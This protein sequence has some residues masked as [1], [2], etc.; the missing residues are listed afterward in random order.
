MGIDKGI[1]SILAN[2]WITYSKTKSKS[3]FSLRNAVYLLNNPLPCPGR[4][5]N[6]YNTKSANVTYSGSLFV[7]VYLCFKVFLLYTYLYIYIYWVALYIDKYRTLDKQLILIT[8]SFLTKRMPFKKCK[9]CSVWF[10]LHLKN[11]Q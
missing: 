7:C 9:I 6:L 3:F 10:C 4:I 2:H 1:N 11:P 5:M 8:L